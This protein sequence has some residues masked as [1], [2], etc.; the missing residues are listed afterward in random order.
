[1][2]FVAVAYLVIAALFVIY[3]LTLIA[4]Q[5]LIVE[6]TDAAGAPRPLR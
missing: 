3:T 6:L 2:G 4:R 1:M 5:R